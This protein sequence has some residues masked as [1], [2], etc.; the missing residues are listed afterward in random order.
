MQK[1]IDIMFRKIHDLEED[2]ARHNALWNKA[3]KRINELELTQKKLEWLI[4]QQQ[5]EIQ[6]LEQ[7]AVNRE[8]Y[9]IELA[10]LEVEDFE[11]EN[12]EKKEDTESE[13]YNEH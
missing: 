2:K 10:N 7:D 8:Q 11:K 6:K 12:M 1:E 13:K 9:E 5:K 3:E 4:E